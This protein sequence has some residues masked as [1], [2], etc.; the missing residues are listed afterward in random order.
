MREYRR[1]RRHDTTVVQTTSPGRVIG[2]RCRSSLQSNPSTGSEGD[3]VGL[4]Q[5]YSSE[6]EHPEE[7]RRWLQPTPA[8]FE[9]SK[10]PSQYSSW[11]YRFWTW[12][13]NL[14]GDFRTRVLSI[15]SQASQTLLQSPWNQSLYARSLWSKFSLSLLLLSFDCFWSFED[16]SLLFI[17]FHA[18]EKDM[19]T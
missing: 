7:V 19:L 14:R 1:A 8:P 13:L 18:A 16:S 17:L 9:Q 10:H 2:F 4:E 12:V 5:D 3:F 6:P 11:Y 15:V